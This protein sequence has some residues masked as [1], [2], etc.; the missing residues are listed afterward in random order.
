MDAAMRA[1]GMLCTLLH[2]AA[3][4]TLY[5]PIDRQVCVPTVTDDGAGPSFCVDFV[6][7][8]LF[9]AAA[10]F[11]DE[12]NVCSGHEAGALAYAARREL[13]RQGNEAE[14]ALR[15]RFLELVSEKE[16]PWTTVSDP[17]AKRRTKI[18]RHQ[19]RVLVQGS[20]PEPEEGCPNQRERA[21]RACALARAYTV[22]DVPC[23]LYTSPSP[24]DATLSRMPSSA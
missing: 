16:D 24:R 1:P 21:L 13:E 9:D 22:I 4:T 18:R 23:L 19:A 3:A 10:R 7:E 17:I 14:R 15:E 5:A 8:D 11:C 12:T 6:R 2:A 20:F